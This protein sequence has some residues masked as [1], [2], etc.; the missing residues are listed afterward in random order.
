ME[1]QK[2]MKSEPMPKRYRHYKGDIYEFVCEATFSAGV[3]LHG[4]NEEVDEIIGRADKAMYKAKK[5]G[6]NRVE[7]AD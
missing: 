3:A 4:A 6:K 7:A 1:G 5:A 2:S